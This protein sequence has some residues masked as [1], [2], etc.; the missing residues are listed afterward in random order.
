MNGQFESVLDTK[1]RWRGRAYAWA[2]YRWD[3]WWKRLRRDLR[4]GTGRSP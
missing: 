2:R 3:A 1:R 4:T